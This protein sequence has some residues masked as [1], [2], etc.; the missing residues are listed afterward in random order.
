MSVSVIIKARLTTLQDYMEAM[1]EI[2]A[3][4]ANGTATSQVAQ[5]AK[6]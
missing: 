6:K 4:Y 5:Q 2:Y 3:N 1:I